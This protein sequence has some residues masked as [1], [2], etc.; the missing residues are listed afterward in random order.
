MTNSTRLIGLVMTAT[1]WAGVAA[2][3]GLTGAGAGD[4]LPPD[5]T[6]PSQGAQTLPAPL[7]QT[8]DAQTTSPSDVTQSAG[9]TDGYYES[10]NCD[11]Y[12]PKDRGLWTE[13][14]PIEST[15]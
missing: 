9:S 3:Q 5:L 8:T 7:G 11:S 12:L 6:L 14:A 13:L 4:D 15:G 1:L 2:A 10:E